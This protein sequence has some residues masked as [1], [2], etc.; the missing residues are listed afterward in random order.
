MASLRYGLGNYRAWVLMLT[1]GYCFG[2]ELTADNMLTYYL[3]D[4]FEL[5]LVTAGG[6]GGLYGL[7]NIFTR[8]TGGMVSDLVAVRYGMRGRLWVLWIIQTL[9][10][11]FCMLL[12]LVDYSLGATITAII[13]FSIFSQQ[14]CGAHFG[15]APFISRRAYGVVSGLI[16]AG[17]NVGGVVTQVIFF[18]GSQTSPV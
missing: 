4:Q 18:A 17:G 7:M 12:G 14:A 6:L 9:G 11:L 1:Y 8:A 15:V 10:G 16:G 5:P 2:I 13:L 3:Y